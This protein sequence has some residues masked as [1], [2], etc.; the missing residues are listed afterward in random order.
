MTTPA[1]TPPTPIPEGFVP[2]NEPGFMSHIGPLFQRREGKTMQLCARVEAHQANPLGAAHG[3]FLMSIID[4]TL[5]INCALAQDH[6]GVVST[7]QLSSNLMSAARVGDVLVSS[8][9]VEQVTRTL[10]FASGRIMVGDRT[11]LTATA[12]FRNP[13]NKQKLE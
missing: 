13:P 3:G 4:V 5:G 8:A 6:D 10:T 12:V 9:I 7:I 2:R 11:I 1:A